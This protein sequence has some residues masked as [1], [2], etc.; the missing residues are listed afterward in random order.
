MYLFLLSLVS[1]YMCFILF[2]IEMQFNFVLILLLLIVVII[3]ISSRDNQSASPS[4]Q[5]PS[6]YAPPPPPQQ[7][8]PDI[9]PQQMP[10]I[11]QREF[12]HQ[13]PPLY[14]QIAVSYPTPPVPVHYG[15]SHRPNPPPPL[16]R[17]IRRNDPLLM[18]LQQMP[19]GQM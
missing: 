14:E 8:A 3:V 13:L 12:Q 19:T 1:V 16:R 9:P 7:D 17:S 18:H 11:D 2:L 10:A 4:T 15:Q 6:T 5:S